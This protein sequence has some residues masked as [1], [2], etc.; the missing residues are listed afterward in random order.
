MR[1]KLLLLLF[2]A[3][4]MVASAA[5][6]RIGASQAA[7]LVKE[8]KAIKVSS[9]VRSR[10]AADAS[11]ARFHKATPSKLKTKVASRPAKAKSRVSAPA[12][13]TS[14][15]ANLYGYVYFNQELMYDEDAEV[16]GLYEFQGESLEN[17]WYDDMYAEEY[18]Y[19]GSGWLRNGHLC[20][21]APAYW[22]PYLVALYYY[23]C[24]FETGEFIEGSDVEIENIDNGYFSVCA[25]NEDDDTVYGFGIN[26]EGENYIFAKT[27]GSNPDGFEVIKT[28][29]IDVEKE[30]TCPY[31]CYNA[32][33]K[34]LYGINYEGWLVRIAAD[35]SLEKL[36]DVSEMGETLYQG[37]MAYSNSAAGFYVNY[38]SEESSELYFIDP[39]AKTVTKIIDMPDEDT[40]SIMICTDPTRAPE[41]PEAPVVKACD[42][43][44]G[45]T[46]GTI[47]IALPVKNVS[48]GDLSPEISWTATI[49]REVYKTGKAA[50]GESVVVEFT[51]LSDDMHAFSFYATDKDAEGTS[52]NTR[53][54]VGNDTPVAPAY[55]TF[56]NGVASWPAVD[57]G[58]H[59][60]YVDASKVEYNV[61]LNDEPVGKTAGTSMTVSLPADADLAVYII[62]VEAT[63]N[64]MTSAPTGSDK[65]VAGKPFTPDV[66]FA[67]T[68]EEA[69]L[70]TVTDENY[71][72]SSWDFY[73]DFRGSTAFIC[74]Y[75]L[76]GPSDDW[77]FLP[78][79]NFA[80]NKNKYRLK[81]DVDR[82]GSTIDGEYYEVFIG[83]E[84]EADAM[85][86]ELIEKTK[87]EFANGQEQKGDVY[88]SVPEAGV[89][90]IGIHCV[91][92][93]NRYGVIVNNISVTD[94][95]IVEV[96][97]EA[98]SDIVA[99]AAEQGEL[100]ANVSFVLP[101]KTVG[102]ADIPETTTVSATVT[103][104]ESVVVSGKPG[105]KVSA[106]V[107]TVQGINTISVIASID[108]N[109]SPE[110]T[111]KVYTGVDNPGMVRNLVVT[112]SDDMLSAVM[113]WEAPDEG[114]NG[115]YIVP[116]NVAYEIWVDTGYG[117]EPYAELGKN[118][119]TY[120][121]SIPAGSVQDFYKIA[122]VT[123]NE[124]GL[125]DYLNS[126]A[127]ILGTPYELPIAEDF[128]EGEYEPLAI[129]PWAINYPTDACTNQ[130][131]NFSSMAEIFND[132]SYTTN[133]IM[134][135]QASA[136]G[137][138][139]LCMSMPRFTTVGL[140]S[141]TVEIVFW[142][143]NK[144]AVP[145]VTATAAAAPDI[146]EVPGNV[147]TADNQWNTL[148]AS[149]PGSLLGKGWVQININGNVTSTEPFVI[150]EEVAVKGVTA[151]VA[152][153]EASSKSIEGGEGVV[154]VRGYAGESVAVFTIDGRTL[155]SV[156]SAS[157]T[158]TIAASAA[159]YV[160]KAGDT[161][162]K[163][164]V[165]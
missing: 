135:Y 74:Y 12:R 161:D 124:A 147:I 18:L 83:S 104:A 48:G 19:Y 90:Y 95:G 146:V 15:G 122:V 77:L 153:V 85:S 41:S 40:L 163:V 70:F 143:G 123:T 149:L 9:K 28:I 125:A 17:L 116:E 49:D 39:V 51:N 79:I 131:W 4:A 108:G 136:N 52:A 148:T 114:A 67:P 144:G 31:I 89:Y 164:V 142:G 127:V 33:D 145:Y 126:E 102:G 36:F 35:G 158:V 46:S 26:G 8:G 73:P 78:A 110:A 76:D 68:P 152:G 100:K 150:I 61:Y 162:R 120:T 21:Y 157:D 66:T 119:F 97:P 62:S 155:A 3:V 63:C 94:P 92:D 156:E 109:N 16:V 1:K 96:S 115:G 65:V 130:K 151:G 54:Y 44:D 88:F 71:D 10:M 134:G 47:T 111:V 22:G 91:S 82:M 165:K 6:P 154:I 75:S 139:Q 13:V 160:V 117:F 30:E 38:T 72:D 69:G 32:A 137:A 112:P 57:E 141:A 159:I 56:E 14:R 107:A 103:G 98:V 106:N 140:E 45:A 50:P 27:P 5:L 37:T 23:E 84:P 138:G 113:T 24:D 105:Q 99:V 133:G 81:F 34:N 64:G 20:G 128:E 42:F 2:A 129:N 11:D 53:F 43:A 58:V 121:F 80:S 7:E 55:V 87:V 118:V 132:D 29:D 101:Q 25:Y 93:Y 86:Q 59:G 60:G